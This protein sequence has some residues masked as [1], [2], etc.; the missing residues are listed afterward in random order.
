MTDDGSNKK[1]F[2]DEIIEHL[3]RKILSGTIPVGER[4]PP[5]R[6]LAAELGT[7]RNTLREALRALEAQGLVKA[8]QGDGVRV[9]DFRKTGELN[10]IAPFFLAA[11]GEDRARLLADML[12]IRRLVAREAVVLAARRA[13]PGEVVRIE[14]LLA[15]MLEAAEREDRVQVPRLELAL[16]R[17]ITEASHSVGGLWLFNSLEKVTLS[18][19][20]AYPG[21]WIT[22]PSFADGWRAVVQAIADEDPDTAG[23]WV[24]K[25]LEQT[26]RM[27]LKL[28]GLE[29]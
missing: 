26:D 10:L 20:D 23:E 6:E 16:Y 22:P 14:K 13:T 5:E 4:L 15:E 2:P 9:L 8:R 19:L 29:D 27:I 3:Q 21:L 11:E 7:N 24:S 28:M 17:A 25:K 12:R 18:L 1:K